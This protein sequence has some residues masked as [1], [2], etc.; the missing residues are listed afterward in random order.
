[1]QAVRQFVSILKELEKQHK[2]AAG[3][4]LTCSTNQII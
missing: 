1:M 4:L 2:P 3:T